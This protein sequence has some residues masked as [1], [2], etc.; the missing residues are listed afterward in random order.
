MNYEISI[1]M[2][3][4]NCADTLDD[5]IQSILNQTF[6]NW[7]L[8]MCDDCSTDNT[9]EIAKRYSKK[10]SNIFVLK[11]EINMGLNYTLNRCLKNVD[12][13]Y[14]AR[15]DGDDI[16]ERN[17]LEKEYD[18]LENNEK[19]ALVSTHMVCFDEKG[20][21]GI[22]KTKEN[23]EKDDFIKSSP[24]CHGACLIRTQA[25]KKVCG[26]SEENK[27]LRIEDWHLWY[28]FYKEGFI[29]Y[30]IQEPLYKM[31]DDRNATKRRKFKYRI[32]E[33]NLK[34]LIINEFGISKFKYIYVLKPLILGIIPLKLYEFLHRYHLKNK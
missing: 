18:F 15:M 28:K 17:R 1:I 32:N 5:A 8:I 4:Y 20:D 2:G 3:I 16:S 9:F 27:F 33:A 22:W 31:R 29:G 26:Y 19:Y 14:V 11:N 34:F 7:K 25:I 21:W 12:T 6:K 10:Y 24:F 30:N 23:P 13:K